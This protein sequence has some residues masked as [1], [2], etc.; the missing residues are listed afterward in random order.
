MI[1]SCGTCNQVHIY[2]F[3]T[4]AVTFVNNANTLVPGIDYDPSQ[5]IVVLPG[6][7]GDIL[8]NAACLGGCTDP[9][10]DNYDASATVDDGSCATLFQDVQI[11][12][13]LTTMHLLR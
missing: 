9:T 13:Q 3:I 4:H 12:Q 5:E 8:W 11:L 6:D 7:P 2:N 10:A 1:D